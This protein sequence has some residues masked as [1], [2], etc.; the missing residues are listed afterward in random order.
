MRLAGRKIELTLTSEPLG[1]E[2]EAGQRS[3]QALP[4]VL[5]LEVSAHNINPTLN[6]TVTINFTVIILQPHPHPHTVSFRSP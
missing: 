2:T 3:K 1:I 6:L 4:D 5:I